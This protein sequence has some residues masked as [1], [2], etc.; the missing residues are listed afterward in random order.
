MSLSLSNVDIYLPVK[1]PQKQGY[2]FINW[3]ETIGANEGKSNLISNVKCLPEEQ[4]I[5]T[6][7]SIQTN[8]CSGNKN[9]F[10]INGKWEDNKSINL[11][12]L[13]FDTKFFLDNENKDLCEC[14]FEVSDNS[15]KCKF[16][17]KGKIK[18]NEQYFS[19][20]LK[21]YRFNKFDEVKEVG[22]CNSQD[23]A[24]YLKIMTGLAYILLLL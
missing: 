20:D 12:I 7:T 23:D 15:M 19:G 16:E 24:Y 21:A 14:E 6:I 11:P 9:A 17:G 10:T 13:D 3:E 8:G 5:Y 18:F 2:E 1:P 4:N 22:I